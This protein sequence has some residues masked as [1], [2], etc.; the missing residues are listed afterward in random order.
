MIPDFRPGDAIQLLTSAGQEGI[1][2]AF[3]LEH[4]LKFRDFKVFRIA[5]PLEHFQIKHVGDVLHGS[6][7][8]HLTCEIEKND[9]GIVDGGYLIEESFGLDGTQ[10]VLQKMEKGVFPDLHGPVQREPKVFGK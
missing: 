5:G 3:H 9:G 8:Q 7:R 10:L 1:E 2:A 4:T 6:T